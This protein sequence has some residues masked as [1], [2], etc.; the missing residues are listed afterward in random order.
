MNYEIFLM[1]NKFF[2]LFFQLFLSIVIINTSE[3]SEIDAHIILNLKQE[4]K[5]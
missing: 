5:K 4:K 1:K 2:I 3:L